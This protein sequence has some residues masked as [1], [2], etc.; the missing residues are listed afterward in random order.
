MYDS[1]VYLE[2]NLRFVFRI[3]VMGI[4]TEYHRG[5]I[6]LYIIIQY[7]NS[8]HYVFLNNNKPL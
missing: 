2:F 3:C 6:H 4:H 8:L 5:Y 7:Y 1:S